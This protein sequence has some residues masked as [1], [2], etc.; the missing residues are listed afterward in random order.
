MAPRKSYNDLSKAMTCLLRHAGKK[1][2]LYFTAGGFVRLWDLLPCLRCHTVSEDVEQDVVE[3][4]NVMFNKDGSPRFEQTIGPD[5]HIWVRATR[6]HT[7]RAINPELP[8]E[9]TEQDVEEGRRH[10]KKNQEEQQWAATGSS[11][12]PPIVGRVKA[13]FKG[14]EFVD[15]EYPHERYLDL[16]RG[17]FVIVSR[18]PAVFFQPAEGAETQ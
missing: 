16:Q 5:Q 10:R 18:F 13:D 12:L 6:K 7:I 3:I 11:Q 1:R 4:V 15:Q 2:G 17:E 9:I 8:A 14:S